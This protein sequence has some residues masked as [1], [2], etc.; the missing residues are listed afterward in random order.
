MA[1]KISLFPV[2]SD[3]M[4]EKVRFQASPYTFYYVRDDE[5]YSLSAEETDSGT[6]V[7]K[8]VD[9]E[10]IWSPDD[11]NIG[12]QRTYSLRTYQ[13]LFGENGI[14]CNNA[15]LGLAIMWASSDSK[16]RDVIQVGEI[17]NVSDDLTFKVNYEFLKAQLRGTVE[18]TTIIYI[19]QTGTPGWG[20][21]HLA[22]Y[23]G[24]ILGEIDKY[25]IKLD[26]TGSFFPVYE[27]HEPGQPLWYVKCDWNDPAYDQF[28]ECVSVYINTGNKNYKYLD[29]TKK[30]FNN[31]LLKEI[32]ATALTIVIAR[33]K[34]KQS[35]WEAMINGDDLQ[36][37]SVSEAVYYFKTTLEWNLSTIESASLSIRKFFDQRM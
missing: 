9:E 23:Y 10:G 20:E 36:P 21:E 24:C 1:A 14:A 27:V 2:L 8:I 7:Y 29:K 26:G 32:M 3:E 17:K 6:M 37:G 33:L 30:T 35:D 25:T 5:E 15:V 13:C 19:K 22:N 34:E 11:Y 12:F 18:F 16:Q 4:L 28:A 31:Q